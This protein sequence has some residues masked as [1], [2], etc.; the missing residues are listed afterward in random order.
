MTD[1]TQA[2]YQALRDTIR[3]RGTARLCAVLVG[4]AAWGA[5]AIAMLITELQG[6][7]TLVPFVVLLATFEINFFIHTGVERIGRYLQVFYEERNAAIGWETTAMSYGAKFPGGLDPLFSAIFALAAA[8]NFLSS[9][10]VAER[11]PGWIALS[12]VAHI[13]FAYRI[14][15]A[16]KLSAAQRALDLDRFRSLLP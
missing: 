5:L 11:R 1:T 13:A 7:I 16:R 8:L 4:L 14:V 12:L 3:E 15:A 2:E 9:L 6:G 10:A